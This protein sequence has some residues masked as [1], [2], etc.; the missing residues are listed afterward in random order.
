MPSKRVHLR[1][2]VGSHSFRWNKT[3]V[4][5]APNASSVWS[6]ALSL[7]TSGNRRYGTLAAQRS[8]SARALQLDINSLTA[9]NMN[10]PPELS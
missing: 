7:M 4:S 5:K 8:Y 3:A 1:F 9:L 2:A 6:L 10:P